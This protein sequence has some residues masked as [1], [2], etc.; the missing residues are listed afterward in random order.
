MRGLACADDANGMPIALQ[1]VTHHVKHSRR[2]M[3]LTQ[4]GGVI[5]RGERNDFCPVLLDE[6]EFTKKIH[7]AFPAVQGF[8]CLGAYAFYCLQTRCRSPQHCRG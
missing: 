8:R 6:G 1:N 7:M 4:Q 2:V 5:R 3:D